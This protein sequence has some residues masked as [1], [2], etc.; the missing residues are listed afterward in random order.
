MNDTIGENGLVPA[1]LVFSII[2]RF[3]IIN[4]NLPSQKERMA[5]ISTA[6]MQMNAIVIER[7]V[8]TAL[9]RNIPPAS[10]RNSNLGDEVLVVSEQQ[11]QWKGPFMVIHTHGRMITV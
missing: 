4:T 3:P 9:S 8:A 5:I 1:L 10:D 6:Q 2:P 11:K 7:R